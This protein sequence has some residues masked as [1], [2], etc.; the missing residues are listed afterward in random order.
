MP[1]ALC[2]VW[3]A[4]TPPP[5]VGKFAHKGLCHERYAPCD[6]QLPLPHSWAISP[7]KAF[8][9]VP[10]PLK[11]LIANL[12]TKALALSVGIIQNARLIL[13]LF[14]ALPV[15]RPKSGIQLL[16][17]GG[18]WLSDLLT[19]HFPWHINKIKILLIAIFL[20]LLFTFITCTSE[21]KFLQ[22]MTE[23]FSN[24][25]GKFLSG[26]CLY[27]PIS[28]LKEKMIFRFHIK[29]HK[30]EIFV[31]FDFEICIISLLVMSK[32]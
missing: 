10:P 28:G 19:S 7:T 11:K 29:V 24:V 14:M 32:Y 30:I 21:N 2:P 25:A 13:T 16:F 12:P 31:V 22:K 15:P 26:K 8:A 18:T 23:R 5:F 27:Q 9:L 20:L 6:S 17:R 1:W 4:T 3:C